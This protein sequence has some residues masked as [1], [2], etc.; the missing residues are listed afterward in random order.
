ML[1]LLVLISFLGIVSL[2]HGNVICTLLIYIGFPPHTGKSVPYVM[3]LTWYLLPVYFMALVKPIQGFLGWICLSVFSLCASCFIGEG[4]ACV[5]RGFLYLLILIFLCYQFLIVKK[6]QNGWLVSGSVLVVLSP[7]RRQTWLLSYESYFL[8]KSHG[9]SWEILANI[10][11]V[12][13]MKNG[14]LLKMFPHNNDDFF[15]P[16]PQMLFWGFKMWLSSHSVLF[17]FYISCMSLVRW[18]DF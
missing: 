1:E 16:S 14:A 17:Y 10:N 4:W 7:F 6:W 13:C 5:R 3:Y 12:C 11:S 18:E 15:F 8:R 9:F 2:S